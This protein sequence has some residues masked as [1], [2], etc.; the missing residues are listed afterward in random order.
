MDT[1]FKF[2][3]SRKRSGKMEQGMG[4]DVVGEMPTV[5]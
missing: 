5:I 3:P 4:I 1:E 2:G